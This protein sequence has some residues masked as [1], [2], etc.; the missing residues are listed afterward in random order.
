MTPLEVASKA[1]HEDTVKVLLELGASYLGPPTRERPSP[2]PPLILAASHGHVGIV[3]LFLQHV[4][5]PSDILNLRRGRE[6]RKDGGG[7]E[8]AL[9]VAAA[10]GHLDICQSL[11]DHGAKLNLRNRNG[12]SALHIAVSPNV[13]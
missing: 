7:G 3:K 13:T 6:R 1:G 12:T 10:K 8:T 11:I 2:P 4:R 9:M 5:N